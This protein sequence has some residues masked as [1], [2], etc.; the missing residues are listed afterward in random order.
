MSEYK[1]S[2]ICKYGDI[3]RVKADCKVLHDIISRQG[4]S[5]LIDVIAEHLG[6]RVA[7][8]SGIT[9]KDINRAIASMLTELHDACRERT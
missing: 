7:K 8:Y 3:D 2:I 1:S 5:L 9:E 4:S 6:K